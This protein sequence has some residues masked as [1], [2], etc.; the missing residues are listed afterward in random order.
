MRVLIKCASLLCLQRHWGCRSVNRF[1][2]VTPLRAFSDFFSLSMKTSLIIIWC[3]CLRLCLDV[4]WKNWGREGRSGVRLRVCFPGLSWLHWTQPGP[5]ERTALSI[6]FD[7]CAKFDE[8]W[9]QCSPKGL[10]EPWSVI[11]HPPC[12]LLKS[13]SSIYFS[14]AL[15]HIICLSA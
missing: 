9:M 13:T 14:C 12:Y 15:S 11:V 10:V 8:G 4:A 2:S 6:L 1:C 7:S 5:S 3:R